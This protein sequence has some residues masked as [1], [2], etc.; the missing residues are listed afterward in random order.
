MMLLLQTLM[1]CRSS[2][3]EYQLNAGKAAFNDFQMLQW[4]KC[5][6][7]LS[8]NDLE[9]LLRLS[10]RDSMHGCPAECTGAA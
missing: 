1:A 2:H 5:H 7:L 9:D 8:T 6:S 10:I 3:R 4:K